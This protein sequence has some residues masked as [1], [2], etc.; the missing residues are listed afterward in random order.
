MGRERERE[1]ERERARA[2][3]RE[4]LSLF[5]EIFFYDLFEGI[6]YAIDLGSSLCL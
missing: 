4:S 3:A 6:F 2:R 1:R 5:R